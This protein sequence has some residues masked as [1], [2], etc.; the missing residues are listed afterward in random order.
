MVLTFN[1]KRK[2]FF[3]FVSSA[4]VSASVDELNFPNDQCVDV[5][6]FFNV[7]LFPYKLTWYTSRCDFLPFQIKPTTELLV[8]DFALNT[9]CFVNGG[10]AKG[11]HVDPS[12]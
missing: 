1:E 8:N 10:D 5:A 6:F 4:C 12:I 9:E 7:L 11:K 2:Y 3:C